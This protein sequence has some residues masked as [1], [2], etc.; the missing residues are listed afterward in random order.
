MR[1]AWKILAIA[2][3]ATVFHATD[4]GVVVALGRQDWNDCRN[5][6]EAD[7]AIRG[8]AAVI[9]SSR[10][11]KADLQDA[12]IRRGDAHQMQGDLKSAIA[13]FTQAI[14]LSSSNANA[15]TN[16]GFAYL[17]EGDYDRALADFN[18][19]IRLRPR[20]SYP[21]G[22]RGKTYERKGLHERADADLDK[23]V[24]LPPNDGVSYAQRAEVA[25][26]RNEFEKAL[27]DLDKAIKLQKEAPMFHLERGEAYVGL[28]NYS[29]AVSAYSEAVRL[30]PRNPIPYARRGYALY[31]Q[32]QYDRAVADCTQAISLN[33]RFALAYGFRGYAY[34][35]KGDY[36]RAVAD[37]SEAIRLSPK[38]AAFYAHRG[39]AYYNRGEYERAQSDFDEA[40]RHN[41][42]LAQAYA[43]RGLNFEKTGQREKAVADYRK[44][45][46][47]P[48][49]AANRLAVATA[50]DA[51]RKR[52]G[53]LETALA[54]ATPKPAAPVP[55]TPEPPVVVAP[56][57]APPP[58]AGGR[59][60]ALVIGNSKYLNVQ[61]IPNPENDAHDIGAALQRLGFDV[62]A[63][64]NL[65]GGAM[66]SALRD[67]EDKS[68][69]A[70]WALVYYAGHGMQLDGKTWL[71]PV[72]ARLE[73][74]SDAPDEAVML[75]RV[76]DRLHPAKGLRLV[77]LDACRNNP[78][79]AQMDLG[80]EAQ[81]G[82]ISRGLA[83]IEPQ[84]GELVFYAA[85]DGQ[86]AKDGESRHSPFAA[87]LLSHIEEPDLEL[88][89][90]V[91]KV[92]S[93]VLKTT[94]SQQEPFVY[95]RLPDQDFFFKAAEH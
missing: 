50:L 61:H 10:A 75:D 91:R 4:S 12:Y 7:R 5:Q 80:K 21:Y 8:C 51:A 9:E 88:G 34:N 16:R 90:L 59:R 65:D 24:S 52:L 67:F 63:R 79:L 2:A 43:N 1:R 71:I 17:A 70:D 66:R 82:E 86:T 32:G 36:D 31:N 13:D 30:E 14:N 6:K 83:R 29:Q 77:M 69:G 85:R 46:S 22:G 84:H 76:L 73:R 49:I 45:L 47:L 62:T 38:T 56:K 26:S 89:R 15:F 87:A 94:G 92:T 33:L 19:A 68:A 11:S 55:P 27:A 48:A 35:G 78:F 54:L 53:V 37:L 20:S 40:I 39:Q 28:G 64:Q 41:P 44:A 57:P 18:V 72:D 74:A 93:D 23:A 25:I 60:T 81:R 42:E 95:G 58:A 3:F